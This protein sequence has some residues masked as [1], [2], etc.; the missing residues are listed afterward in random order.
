MAPCGI[1]C[2]ARL[3]HQT[4]D[5]GLEKACAS[6]ATAH[7]CFDGKQRIKQLLMCLCV[8]LQS[9]WAFLPVNKSVVENE[10]RVIC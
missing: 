4:L 6:L 2:C 5:T 9:S 3:E 1:H 10:Y 7:R 8:S